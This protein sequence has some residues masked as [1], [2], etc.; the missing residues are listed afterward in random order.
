V[1]FAQTIHRGEVNLRYNLL[2][3]PRK[4]VRPLNEAAAI[5][6]GANT[7]AEGFLFAIAAALILGESYRSSRN[8][9][10]RRL[11]V[12]D[13]LEE[14]S[15]KVDELRMD[16]RSVVDVWEEKWV[17]ERQRS[18]DITKIVETLVNIGMRGGFGDFA[19]VQLPRSVPPSP[20]PSSASNT[21]TPPSNPNL[22][23]S[24]SDVD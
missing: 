13:Q 24:A 12:D 23:S 20:S 1:S 18:E 19:N 15:G 21:S 14:L 11:S 6:S 4:A 10:H 3:Q 16:L 9:K 8:D 7:L 5:E 22:G 17:E 2:G